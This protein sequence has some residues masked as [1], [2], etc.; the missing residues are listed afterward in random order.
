MEIPD[1][2]ETL[3]RRFIFNPLIDMAESCEKLA[4]RVIRALPRKKPVIVFV[5][6]TDLHDRRKTLEVLGK[7]CM[8][9]VSKVVRV[10]IDVETVFPFKR[11][12]VEPGRSWRKDELPAHEWQKVWDGGGRTGR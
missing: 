1:T 12:T 3:I 6:E 2:L 8:T 9:R 11:L 7:R 5:D 10:M 4:R